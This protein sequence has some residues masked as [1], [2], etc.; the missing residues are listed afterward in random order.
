MHEIYVIVVFETTIAIFNSQTGGFLEE[1]GILDKFKYKGASLNT[2]V[3]DVVLIS[4]NNSTAKNSINT[5]MYQLK[6]IPAQDQIDHL[7]YSCR[8][9]EAKE[10]FVLKVN[11]TDVD[12]TRKKNQFFLDCGWIRFIRMLDFKESLNDFKNTKLDPRELILL[13]RTILGNNENLSKH[14]SK[15]DTRFDLSKVIENFKF[16]NNRDDINTI[17]MVE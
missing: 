17:S 4:H 2:E 11:K 8:I 5:K 15:T 14:F 9:Q 12:F 6:E 16:D 13:Y 10:V 3:G 7:L 1:Q